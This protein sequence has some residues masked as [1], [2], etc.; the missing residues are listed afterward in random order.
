M[1]IRSLA[2]VPTAAFVPRE[3]GL[4][5]ID[6]P[7]CAPRGAGTDRARLRVVGTGA[8]TG[9]DDPAPVRLA[10]P[11]TRPGLVRRAIDAWQAAAARR[12]RAAQA[13]SLASLDARTLRDLGIEPDAASRA[14]RGL[15]GW[16]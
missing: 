3:R 1:T 13:R 12:R 2:A 14:A 15:D 9:A 11:P 4:S 10:A 8:G 16:R 5:A 6:A 7:A